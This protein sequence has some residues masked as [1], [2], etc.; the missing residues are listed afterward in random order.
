MNPLFNMDVA[1]HFF[2]QWLR[3]KKNPNYYHCGL[4]SQVKL[5]QTEAAHMY[6][7]AVRGNLRDF[8][9]GTHDLGF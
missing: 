5:S 3:C 9:V 8:E 7:N 2:I 6:E 4:R 1:L